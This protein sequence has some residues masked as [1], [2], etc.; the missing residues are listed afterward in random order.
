[1]KALVGYTGFV[2]SNLE[3][4]GLFDALYN[5]KNIA[6][7][8]DTK[9]D[10]LYFSGIPAEK[11][12]A[13]TAPDKDRAVIENAMRTIERI[14]PKSVVLIS[15]VDVY[16]RPLGVDEDT[17]IETGALHPYGL[18]R[19]YLEEFVSSTFDDHLIA[20]L[21]GLYGENLKK[22]FIYDMIYFLPSMLN[23]RK[24]VELG[25]GFLERFYFNQD[26]GFYKLRDIDQIERSE[27][28]D[29][30]KKTGFSALNFTDSRAKF[31]FYNLKHLYR[32]L[33]MA[34]EGGIRLL[35]L[36]VEPCEAGELY[37]FIFGENFTNEITDT[38]PDYDMKTKYSDLFEGKTGY[39]FDKNV[40]M[41]DIKLFVK[42]KIAEQV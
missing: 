29:F 18:N 12:L 24:M 35:N 34:R 36:A 2:G 7:A 23:E 21:P 14:R 19:Y 42:S 33:K 16:E 1:M 17:K 11:F 3:R 13:N 37:Q 6:N 26:N 31:Q 4:H 27:L 28:H 8:Y 25:R 41:Q 38:P 15:T 9:P 30:F 10:I 20:R 32:Q 5:S 22:N 40:V 39:L